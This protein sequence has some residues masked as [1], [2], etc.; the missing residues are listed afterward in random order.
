MNKD[1][2]NRDLLFRIGG[3]LF[4]ALIG[5][6]TMGCGLAIAFGNYR[7]SMILFFAVVALLVAV[8]VVARSS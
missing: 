1:N 4:I 5:L 2:H 6:A 8:K 3:L 7:L